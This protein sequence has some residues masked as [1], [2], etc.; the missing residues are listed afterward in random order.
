MLFLVDTFQLPVLD[1]PNKEFFLWF[2]VFC[3]ICYALHGP[4]ERLLDRFKK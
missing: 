1:L 4:F 2:L 3:L